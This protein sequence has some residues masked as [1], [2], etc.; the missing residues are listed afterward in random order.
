[1][2]KLRD[3]IREAGQRR[4]RAFGFV[5]REEGPETPRVLVMAEVDGASAAQAAV[6]AGAGALLHV[7]APSSVGETVQAADGAP[8]GMRI[9]GATREDT[10]ALLEAGADFVIFDAAQTVAEALLERKLGRIAVAP[11]ATTDDELRRYGAL[12]LDAILVGDPGPGLS[13]L[14]QLEMRR[15]A[16]NARAPLAVL[17]GSS[18]PS[19]SLELWRNAGAGLVI[20]PAAGA[21]GDVVQAARDVPPPPEPGQ[22]ERPQPLLPQ[23]RPSSSPD[24]EDDD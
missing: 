8:V 15:M 7:G 12:D 24:D 6:Q 23:G 3:R 4:T 19:P 14:G 21:L 5:R 2:S 1:M 9:D 18:Q 20:V 22:E 10:R 13:V 17:M 16:E 11:S